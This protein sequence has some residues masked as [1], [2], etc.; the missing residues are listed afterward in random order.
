MAAGAVTFTDR[1]VTATRSS[2]VKRLVLA[3]LVPVL[4]QASKRA[5]V[6]EPRFLEVP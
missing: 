5:P 2:A 3:H 6:N 4:S 1:N